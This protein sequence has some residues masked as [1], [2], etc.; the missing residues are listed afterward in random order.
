MIEINK[1]VYFLRKKSKKLV[2]L[3]RYKYKKMAM[4][5]NL[6]QS[7]NKL[8]VKGTSK[9]VKRL[10]VGDLCDLQISA[11]GPKGISIDE[12]SYGY[13]VICARDS[14]TQDS[15]EG[16]LK[17]GDK[18]K[19]KVLKVVN[20]TNQNG[21]NKYA[22]AK[23]IKKDSLVKG[24]TEQPKTNPGDVL[25]VKVTK[26]T[27]KGGSIA[28]ITPNYA[29]IIPNSSSKSGQTEKVI[30]TRVKQ[31]YAFAK[32]VESETTEKTGSGRGLWSTSGALGS[33]F[34][35]INGKE[36]KEGSK[37]TLRLPKKRYGKYFILKTLDKTKGTHNVLFIK[38][39]LGAKAGDKVRI[40]FTKVKKAF[41][42]AKLI[43]LNPL[44]ILKKQTLVRNSIRQMVKNGMHFGEKAVKCNARMK[45]Y[46]WLKNSTSSL[47]LK[48]TD[49]LSLKGTDLGDS[50]LLGFAGKNQKTERPLVKK[51]RHLINLFKT[52]RCLN[53]ALNICSKYALKGRTFLFIGTKKPAA[54][55]IARASLFSKSSF[56]VN[57]RWLGGMLTNWKTILK[58]ISKIRPILKEKQKIIRDILEKRQNLKSR[59]IKKALLLK[60]KSKLICN[61]GHKFISVLKN[62]T[63]KA[64]FLENAEQLSS[65][66]KELLKNNLTLLEKRQMLLLKRRELMVQSQILKDKGLELSTRYQ[67]LLTQLVGYTQKLREYKYLLLISKEIHN[68]KK[69]AQQSMSVVNV[70]YSKLNALNSSNS[71]KLGLITNP[72]KVILNQIVLLMQSKYKEN[73]QVDS[74]TSKSTSLENKRVLVCSKLL[75]QFSRFSPYI[76]S[77]ILSVQNDIN[78]LVSTI[79]NKCLAQLNQIQSTLSSYTNLK[80]KVVNELQAIKAKL[81]AERHVIR[82]IKKKLKQFNAQK[83]LVKLLPRLRYLPTPQTKISET[84]QILMKKIVDPKLKYPIDQIYKG[85]LPNKVSMSSKKVAAARKQKWQRLEKYFGGIANM[86][87]LNKASILQNVAIIVGQKEEMNAVR[88]C[89]KLGIKMFNVVDTN[90]NPSFADHVVPANDDSRNSIKY[91]LHKFL[92]HIR[93]STKLR[94]KLQKRLANTTAG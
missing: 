18:V 16:S 20:Q 72:P 12:Y 79:K 11:L 44:S 47:S 71:Q 60:K 59:L 92:T 4:T 24:T 40:K 55:L 15:V 34:A 90:C 73:T 81:T 19:A 5:K 52:R 13:S 28:Q 49:S 39:S 67:S 51:G 63:S 33:I 77:Q 26:S 53:K 70:S 50:S 56:Y 94:R 76:K 23:V 32:K 37:V 41:S 91:I 57:T 48:G 27:L 1:I 46:L 10:N 78:E 93:L 36:I 9:K 8:S 80:T 21:L 85:V 87:K 66:R 22:I 83:R 35:V 61:L 86:T 65:K 64:K 7:S 84:V 68:I 30:V 75:S 69:T 25:E 14:N 38:A 58:S 17:L 89:Q 54:G 45:N 42:V 74:I 82:I 43:Q 31:N 2:Y 88:E 6:G 29:I 62:P 3:K